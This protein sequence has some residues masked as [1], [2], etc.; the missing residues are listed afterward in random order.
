MLIL[1]SNG[2][3][4]SKGAFSMR[5]LFTWQ[6]SPIITPPGTKLRRKK[7]TRACL[8]IWFPG[9]FYK[10]AG[11]GGRRRVR[12]S[13]AYSTSTTRTWKGRWEKEQIKAPPCTKHCMTH[14]ILSTPAS[15]CH[16]F[17][18]RKPRSE[19]LSNLP[20]ATQSQPVSDWAENH[21]QATGPKLWALSTPAPEGAGAW[22]G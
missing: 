18:Q 6:F 9:S 21:P 12:G 19:R 13:H 17:Q 4:I 14:F 20:Q 15:G 2:T 16:H 8:N 22:L 1:L 5:W 11:D 7:W 3:K 10:V